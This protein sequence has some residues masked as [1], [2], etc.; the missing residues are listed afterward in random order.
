MT[1]VEYWIVEDLRAV[2]CWLR[3]ADR[4]RGAEHRPKLVE[5]PETRRFRQVVRE[6][7]GDSLPNVEAAQSVLAGGRSGHLWPYLLRRIVWLMEQCRARV[8]WQRSHVKVTTVN[9]YVNDLCHKAATDARSEGAR[10]TMVEVDGEV[11]DLYPEVSMVSDGLVV[12]TRAA[13]TLG[14]LNDTFLCQRLRKRYQGRTPAARPV[15]VHCEQLLSWASLKGKWVGLDFLP[16]PR[17]LSVAERHMY[18]KNACGDWRDFACRSDGKCLLCKAEEPGLRHVLDACGGWRYWQR[19]LGRVALEDELEASGVGGE[20]GARLMAAVRARR[21]SPPVRIAVLLGCM[22]DEE[23]CS[24]LSV[25]DPVQRAKLRKRCSVV[26]MQRSASM[27]IEYVK[28]AG[29]G[30]AA[31]SFQPPATNLY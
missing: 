23:W 17:G 15:V 9:S 8:V 20:I 6:G 3:F 12:E 14:M 11:E 21:S 2:G 28:M 22:K 16:E 5:T 27:C 26:L 4:R 25:N 10:S 19:R 7:L 13:A 31:V 24:I 18:I 29:Q 30:G 1:A